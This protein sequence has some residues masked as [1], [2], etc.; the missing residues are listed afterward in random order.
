MELWI[1]HRLGYKLS[2]QMQDLT[3][4]QVAFLIAGYNE[5]LNQQQRAM[6]PE[7]DKRVYDA[8]SELR[9]RLARKGR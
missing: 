3:P 9:E 8:K 1:L 4:V 5:E 2:N 7:R 6:L